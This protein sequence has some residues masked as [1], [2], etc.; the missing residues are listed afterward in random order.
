[1]WNLDWLF[2]NVAGRRILCFCTSTYH[3]HFIIRTQLDEA[4][5]R[6]VDRLRTDFKE[7]ARLHN[8]D[9]SVHEDYVKSMTA[10]M[11]RP[12]DP[13]EFDKFSEDDLQQLIHTATRDLG[14]WS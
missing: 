1:M 4:K 13:K 7:K 8:N 3:S 10:H 9:R 12:K 14:E 5:R 11:N 6:E 2:A